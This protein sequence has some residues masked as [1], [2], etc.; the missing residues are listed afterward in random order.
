MGSSPKPP[1]EDPAVKRLRARQ[2]EELAEL[3]EEEN[4]RLKRAFSVSRGVRAFTRAP[5]RGN[6]AAANAAG[7][8]VSRPRSI[9]TGG[10]SGGPKTQIP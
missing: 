10:G 2:I 3:D 4:E 9:V 6:N 5:T 1:A 7:G 8:R